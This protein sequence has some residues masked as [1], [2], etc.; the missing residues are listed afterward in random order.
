MCRI[1]VDYLFEILIKNRYQI[2][3]KIRQ[4]GFIIKGSK[5]S[6]FWCIVMLV[7]LDLRRLSVLILL[8]HR[9]TRLL[10]LWSMSGREDR[11]RSLMIV[12]GGSWTSFIVKVTVNKKLR[13][14]YR[15]LFSINL[16]WIVKYWT[17]QRY[18]DKIKLRPNRHKQKVHQK[19]QTFIYNIRLK[20]KVLL[21][22]ITRRVLNKKAIKKVTRLIV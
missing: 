7:F 6:M 5:K 9:I 22:F 15:T 1:I 14:N 17:S 13:V 8:K 20:L 10:R 11:G 3:S 2:I 21:K 19:S 4:N 12:S 16:S 18:I